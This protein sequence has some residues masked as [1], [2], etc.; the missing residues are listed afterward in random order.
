MNIINKLILF[1]AFSVCA[2]GAIG[3]DNEWK[4]TQLSEKTIQAAHSITNQYHLCLDQKLKHVKITGKD[5]RVVTDFVLKKCDHEL[6]PIRELFAKEQVLPRISN[7]YIRRK[8]TQAARKILP[9]VMFN[10]SAQ[11]TQTK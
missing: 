3:A 8:R 5:S 7:R 10:Q 1:S 9:L 11:I 4:T 2:Y 6:S